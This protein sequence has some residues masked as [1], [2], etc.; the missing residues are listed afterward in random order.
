[1]SHL[2]ALPVRLQNFLEGKVSQEEVWVY[3]EQ[4]DVDLLLVPYYDN[5]WAVID[6]PGKSMVGTKFKTR[7]EAKRFLDSF[8]RIRKQERFD[9]SASTH[10]SRPRGRLGRQ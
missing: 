9:T 4:A 8:E 7:E 1:M 6:E 2:Q 3:S 10:F 5:T